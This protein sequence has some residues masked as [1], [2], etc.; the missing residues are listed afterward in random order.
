MRLRNGLMSRF[1]AVSNALQ[2]MHAGYGR[3]TLYLVH[4]E[5]QRPVHHAV[6]HETMLPGI[7]L[8]NKG[9]SVGGHIMERGRRDHPYR[10][11][12]RSNHMKHQPKGIGRWSSLGGLA[13][14]GHEAGAL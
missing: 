11:L 14:R 12:K 6:N 10:I 4:G 3:E 8:R 7:D 1:R 9:A 2:K 5:Y 13:E